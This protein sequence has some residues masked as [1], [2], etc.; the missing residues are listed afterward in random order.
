MR[1]CKRY[2]YINV[3]GGSAGC[4]LAARLSKDP[5]NRVLLLEA[6]GADQSPLIRIP[7]AVC[8][9]MADGL[10]SWHHLTEPAK[11][12]A[13]RRIDFPTG[14][15]IGGGSSISGMV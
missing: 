15:V 7:I 12:V 1:Q 10:Y 2:T 11:E 8:K 14:K 6:G 9:M 13:G 4:V 3:G 5:A